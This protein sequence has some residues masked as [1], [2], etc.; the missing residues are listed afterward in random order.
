MS[1]TARLRIICNGCQ[2]VGDAVPLTCNQLVV[3]PK[4]YKLLIG[5]V[6]DSFEIV[7]KLLP[8]FVDG[9]DN[10]FRG[11]GQVGVV[12]FVLLAADVLVFGQILLVRVFVRCFVIKFFCQSV[13]V[14]YLVRVASV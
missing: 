11:R 3:I 1:G 14:R 10:G 4:H 12:V 6:P 7:I 2:V 13:H 9:A 8:H 5:Y